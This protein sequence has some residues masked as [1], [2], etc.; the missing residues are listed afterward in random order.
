MLF[1]ALIAIPLTVYLAQQQ[2]ETQSHANPTTTLALSPASVTKAVGENVNLDVVLT[3]GGNQ[4]NFVKLA[5]KF[6]PTKLEANEQSFVVDPLSNLSVVQGP[7]VENDTLTVVLSVQND[8]TKVIKTSTKIGSVAFTTLAASSVP[9]QIS[10]DATQIQIR[11]INSGNNDAFNENV[12]TGQGTAASVTIQGEVSPTASPTAIPTVEATETPDPTIE[13][14]TTPTC[15][16]LTPDSTTGIAPLTV[17]FEAV[18]GEPGGSISKV[19]FN[20]GDGQTEDVTTGGGLGTDTVDITQSH[21]YASSGSFTATA[22]LTDDNGG[23]SDSTNC[24]QLITVSSGGEASNSATI[25]PLEATGPSTKIVG[26]GA[27]GG[28]LFLIGALLFLA[29]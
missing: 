2:Q 14:G 9:T 10:F 24:S 25:T 5:L 4:V 6:D 11:S 21:E 26:L 3:P 20:Y 1:V 17:N 13:A 22:V 12:Y 15:D 27:I 16:S 8:P 7:T 23:I 18:G 19:T 29:L 28:V